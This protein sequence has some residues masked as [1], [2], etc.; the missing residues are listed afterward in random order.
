MTEVLISGCCGKMGRAVAAAIYEQNDMRIVGGVDKAGLGT[1]FSFPV[2]PSF[3]ECE[4]NAD[5]VID[6]TRPDNIPS[7]INYSNRTGAALVIATTGLSNEDLDM[8]YEHSKKHP[9]FMSTNMSLGVNLMIDLLK[10]AASFLGTDYEVEIIEK[11]H[12]QKVDAPSGTA[13]TMAEAISSAMNQSL[14]LTMGRH[15]N[16]CKRDHYEL[17]IHAVR[18]G[19]IVGEHDVLFIGSEEI[20]EITHSAQSRNVFAYGAVRAARFLS[21]KAPG[22]YSMPDMLSDSE[23]NL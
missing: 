23:K 16:N 9:V 10:K 12:N 15:N 14:K 18:G 17:G 21:G 7:L 2:F 20:I 6:F 4:L 1:G 5:V 19:N 22:L 8:V 13:L 3:S 11:H